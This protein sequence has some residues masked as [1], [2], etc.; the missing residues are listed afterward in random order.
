MSE[1]S[2]EALGVKRYRT[3]SVVRPCIAALEPDYNMGR[4]LSRLY[5]L[6]RVVTTSV[7]DM[8]VPITIG[9]P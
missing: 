6:E 8:I 7:T 9:L 1:E 4:G 5:Y 3:P 2:I